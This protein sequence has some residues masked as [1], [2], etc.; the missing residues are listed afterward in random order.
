MK[1]RLATQNPAVSDREKRH[2]RIAAELAAE[3]MV[4]LENKGI[5]PFRAS[6]KTIALFGSGA[7]RTHIGGTGSGEVN[8]RDFISIE[9]GLENAGY[10]ISTKAILGRDE[11]NTDKA[12]Q[13]YDGQIRAIAKEKGPLIALLSKMGKP[14][15]PPVLPPLDKSATDNA[16]ACIYVLSRVCGEG[17]D[18]RNEPGDFQLS[19][20]ETTDIKLLAQ[21]YERFVLLLNVGGAVDITEIRNLPGAVLLINQGGISTGDA[22]ASI[23]SGKTCPSGHLAAT[24][25]KRYEDWPCAK[26]FGDPSDTWYREGSLVGYRWFDASKTE[27][28]YPFGYGL[29]YANFELRFLS[30]EL[31]ADQF[32]VSVMVANRGNIA[33]KEVVQLYSGYPKSLVAFG[34]TKL[35]KL[36]ETQTVLLRFSAR[37]LSVYDEGQSAWVIRS[38]EIPLYL[39]RHANCTKLCAV[40]KVERDIICEKCRPL[41]RSEQLR[42]MKT[43]S[44][45]ETYDENAIRLDLNAS[46]IN[47]VFNDYSDEKGIDEKA[48]TMSKEELTA[49]CVGGARISMGDF[50]VIGNAS[51]ELPGAAGETTSSLETIGIPTITM[52]DGPA[53]LRVNPK[54]YEKDGL[55]IKNPVEDPIFGLILPPEMVKADLSGTVTKYQYCTALPIATLLAQTWDMDVLEKAGNLIGAEMEEAGISLWLAPAMNIQ[56]NP[57]CGRNYEYY[58]E[59]P[60]LT[61][62][63]AAAVTK[64]VQ[65]HKGCGVC[66]KHLACNNQETNRNYSNSHISEKTLRE[67]YLRGFEICVKLASPISAMTSMNLINGIHTANDRDLLTHAL[68]QEW[69]FDGAVMTDWGVTVD[70]GDQSAQRYLCTS[71]TDCIKAGNDLIMP[72]AQRDV[73]RILEALEDGRLTEHELRLSASHI[74]RMMRRLG[75]IAKK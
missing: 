64:G 34:K 9:K 29:S 22:V 32:S 31:H 10:T 61:G 35:L 28:L 21:A 27:P 16:D 74:L 6:V 23:L 41:F 50:S 5:L 43:F 71:T 37:D 66:I 62:L 4:L 26:E 30:A 46:N 68:R 73:D 49:L 72:G 13:V 14:F 57:L 65:Q 2:S 18:R 60:L 45:E 42:V 15:M 75:L 52:A 7:R 47:C 40:I 11:A 17:A 67:I 19:E 25:P 53:G 54:I 58:S 38:G 36:G 48:K 55:Y 20:T 1:N 59:D 39:A 44:S 8:V 24:W 69:G 51:S 33:G 3:G 70:I 12:K 63:C 56:R